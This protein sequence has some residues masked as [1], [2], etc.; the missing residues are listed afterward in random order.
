M[1][2]RINIV[3]VLPEKTAGVL[4]RVTT[5]GARS[6]FID[7]AVLDYV[8]TQ[9]R[10]N[11]RERLKEGYH[12]NAE[13]DLDIAAKRFPLEEEAWKA[14]EDS[15]KAAETRETETRMT[16]PRKSTL[17]NLIRPEGRRSGKPGPR[18][19]SRTT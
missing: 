14:F 19:S 2:K 4:D 1:N 15:N 11:L 12:V 18:L 6:R 17:S 3:I 16:F 10:Q 8:E 13:R 5:K 9:G 7:R